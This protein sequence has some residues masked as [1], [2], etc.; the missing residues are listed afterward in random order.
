MKHKC[1]DK[2]KF[3]Y[4]QIEKNVKILYARL[5]Y[6]IYKMLYR[7]KEYIKVQCEYT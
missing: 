4:I 2:L 1:K 7:W 5:L 6:G 3:L